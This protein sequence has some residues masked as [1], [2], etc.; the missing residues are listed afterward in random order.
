MYVQLHMTEPPKGEVNSNVVWHNLGSKCP[1]ALYELGCGVS[2]NGP[3]LIKKILRFL[4]ME[5]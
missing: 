1:L 3:G 2:I 4:E 5:E